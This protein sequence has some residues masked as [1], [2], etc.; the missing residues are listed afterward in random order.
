M[1]SIY[2]PGMGVQTRIKLFTILLILLVTAKPI[3]SQDLD[4][5]SVT[6]DLQKVT[7]NEG[8]SQINALEGVKLSYNPDHMADKV[9]T[10]SFQN[11][12][13]EEV[14]TAVLGTGF[15]FKYRGSY[16]IIQPKGNQVKRHTVKLSGAVKDAQTGETIK[17][18]TV[19]EVNKLNATLT[20]KRGHFDLVV[21]AKTDYTTF[22]ISRENYQDT[23]IRVQYVSDMSVSLEPQK[24]EKSRI[25]DRFEIESKKLVKFFTPKKSRKN[26]RNVAMQEERFFQFSVVPMVG[27][28]GM[29]SG[30]VKNN[31][32]LN[33]LAGYA[34]GVNGIELGGFFNI[35]RKEMNGVQIGG[36]GNATGGE[37][38]GVQLGGFINTTKGYTKG[39]QGAGFFNLVTDSIAGTQA[40]GFVNISK[41]MRG[42][43]AAGFV[44]LSIGKITGVQAA[45]FTN[46]SKE[47]KGAQLSGFLNVAKETEGA[48][49]SGFLNVTKKLKGIQLGLINIAD[50]VESGVP[51]GLFSFVR[52][53]MHQLALEHNEFMPYNVSFRAG[54]PKFYSVVTA[55]IDPGQDNLWNYGLGL[56]TQLKLKNKW[57]GNIELVAHHIQNPDRDSKED[58][59]NLLN[60]LNFNVGYQIGKHLSVNAGPVLNLYLTNIYDPSTDTFG[61]IQRS[62]F[63]EKRNNNRYVLAWVGYALSVRF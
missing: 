2:L 29:L 30:Q 14:L 11:Q 21:S 13:I 10:Q 57:Y 49:V 53:G 40:A 59:L 61:D 6:I 32:S 34:Y 46:L 20:D 23:I 37:S 5:R 43:Q 47:V 28:N 19:Y 18:A 42:A 50:T 26:V 41:R 3:W 39:V 52:K 56:G 36:F 31:L 27:T 44:N 12:P 54:V 15:N 9:V 55:G 7:V 45:G 48:Q 38:R 24:K 35:D 22:A 17:D 16:I 33:L 60:R 58:H 51:I 25:A 62:G 1:G 4:E 8:L 63:Y